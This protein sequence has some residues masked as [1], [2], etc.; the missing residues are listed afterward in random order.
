MQLGSPP[1]A[2]M[3]QGSG[4]LPFP[5]LLPAPLHRRYAEAQ[6]LGE[7]V[8][9]AFTQAIWPRPPIGSAGI[10]LPWLA[11]SSL[12]GATQAERLLLNAA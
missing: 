9:I 6:S 4:P 11:E 12:G 1:H 8:H 2:T 10:I 7:N 5:P 3:H